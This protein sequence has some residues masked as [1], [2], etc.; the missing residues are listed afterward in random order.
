MASVRTQVVDLL[1]TE[2]KKINGA[3]ATSS[4]GNF[5]DPYVFKSNVFSENV[6]RNWKYLEE[7]NDFPTICFMV[8]AVERQHVGGDVRYEFFEV[9]FRGYVHGEDSLNLADDL[10]D[11][12]N[13]VVNSFRDNALITDSSLEISD[14]LVLSLS[15]DEGL[16][17][18]YGICDV[19][20][21]ISYRYH[22]A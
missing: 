7:I 8:G 2:L 17:D 9:N 12:I 14:A 16:Y 1:I 10:A 19:R 22:L 4:P 13:F 5:I 15:T 6:F 11:D 3:T 20:S 21:Q 18:P